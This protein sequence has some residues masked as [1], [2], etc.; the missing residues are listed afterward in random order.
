M[1][2][3]SSAHWV[4]ATISLVSAMQAQAPQTYPQ[5]T[6]DRRIHQETPM[7]PPPRNVVFTDP[8]FGSLMIRATDSATNFKNPGTFLRS[9]AS[10][11]ANEWSADT[12]KLYVLGKGGQVLVFAFDPATMHISSLPN[13]APGKG[14]LLPLRPGP[15]FAFTDPDLIY[16]TKSPEDLTITSYRFSTNSSTPVID[17]R[18]C[19]VQPPLGTGPSVVSDTVVGLSLNDDRLSIAEGGPEPGKHMFVVVYDKAL[20][21]RWYNTQTGQIG[22]SWGPSGYVS[23]QDKYLIVHAYLSRSGR[24]VRIVGGPSWSEHRLLCCLQVSCLAR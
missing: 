19:G 12:T 11:E 14:L 20:G 23:T 6:T 18:N 13:A 3:T 24:Y 21:C 16:G 15:T 7:N 10:G 1:L 9:E 2:S 17:T 22:G 5:A 8:D 4:L